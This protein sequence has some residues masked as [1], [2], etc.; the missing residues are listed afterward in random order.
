MREGDSPWKRRTRPAQPPP[1]QADVAAAPLATR[2][3]AELRL[4]GLNAVQAVF[5]KRPQAIRKLYLAE[6][7]IPSLQPL[8]K[9]CVANRIG[10]RVVAEGIETAP[11]YDLLQTWGCEQGQG[12][13][14]A[15]PMPVGALEAWL[16]ERGNERL[17]A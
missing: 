9:W 6:S 10:Y 11:V 17:S 5:A 4:H 16:V 15:Q 3:E 13:L 2:R 1:A 7:R 14:M 8:L 12:Y